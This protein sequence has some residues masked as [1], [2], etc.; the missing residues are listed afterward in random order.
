MKR[1]NI[2]LVNFLLKG[3]NNLAWSGKSVNK[4]SD[5]VKNG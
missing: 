2:S 3:D 4:C 5:R 1:Q